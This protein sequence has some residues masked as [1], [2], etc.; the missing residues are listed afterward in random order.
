MGLG[1]LFPLMLAGMLAAGGPAWAQNYPERSIKLVLPFVPGGITD[2]VGRLWAEKMKGLLGPIFVE[3]QGGAGGAVGAAAVV[4]AQ[5]DG[6]T[7][8]LGGTAALVV[9]PATARQAPYDPAK[10]LEPISILGLTAMTIAI[11]PAVPAQNLQELIDF[12][13]ANPGKLS[14][15][16]GGAGSM[17]HL[18][19]ELF[20]SLTQ[21]SHIVHVPYKGGGQS[22]TDLVSGHIPMVATSV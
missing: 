20:K 14:Y 9:I 3:N 4:R 7:L 22:I 16:S 2:T 11:H 19:G 15:G 6:Y 13:K 5:P 10:D 17:A 1:R 18:T 8:L 12:A 21:T